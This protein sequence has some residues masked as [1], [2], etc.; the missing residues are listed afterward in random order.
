VTS[1]SFNA[2]AAL[3]RARFRTLLR[4]RAAA[5]AGIGTQV[6]W[7]L[8]KVMILE[9][10][11]RNSTVPQPMSFRDTVTY[12]WLGQ[13]FLMML[14]FT[15]NPDPEV[16]QMIRTGA[17]AYEL[18]RPLDLYGLWYTRALAARSA[19]T[20]L[21]SVPQ[22]VI[23][24]TFFGMQPPPSVTSAVAWLAA[25]FGA[26]LLVSAVMAFVTITLLWT[27][28]GDG[29]AR[30]TPSLAMLGAGLI[31]PLPLFPAW[32]RPIFDFLPFRGMAD[33]PFR[34]YLGHL[35]PSALGGVLLHQFLWT[36][37]FVW[38]GRAL[39][40]RGLNRLVVQGG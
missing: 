24:M 15:A 1:A 18:T 32:A 38:A 37:F 7:G 17:V 26:L 25:T 3:F 31:I 33:A 40:A 9:A 8:L 21:R 23:A 4:Y 22:F 11:Y 27:V 29:V 36:A 13:A 10:F 19:P 20:L 28:S 34:L 30:I 5:L 16:R 14:P 39:L 35:P 12:T 6:F 2:Y